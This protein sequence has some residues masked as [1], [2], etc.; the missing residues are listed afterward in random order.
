[1][2]FCTKCGAQNQDE[3]SVCNQCGTPLFPT[4]MSSTADKKKIVIVASAVFSV[5]VI[6][7]FLIFTH[8]ICINHVFLPAT[9]ISPQ[10]CQYCK[11]TQGEPSEHKWE[12]ATCIAPKYCSVCLQSVGEPSGHTWVDATCVDPKTCS[13]CALTDGI[14]KGHTWQAATCSIPETCVDCGLTQG[15]PLGHSVD[16]WNL[17]SASTCTTLGIEGGTCSICNESVEQ[18]LPLADHILGDWEVVAEPSAT[19]DGKHIKKCTHCGEQLESE[20]F[21]LSA[22]ELQKYYK[23]KSEKISYEKL[24]RTPSKYEGK[25]IRFR[26][27]VVQVCSEA[28]SSLYYSSYR[29]ATSSY[30]GNVIYIYVDNYGSESRILED[31]TIDFYGVFDGLYTYETVLGAT[32]TI[33]CMTV[34]YVAL[35]D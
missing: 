24:A 21:S 33:P 32:V 7:L 17:I 5:I 29:V 19:N 25:F 27:R 3:S 28:T 13:T 34:E 9:C 11:K 4:S 12:D 10:I 18:D 20:N 14:S 26:G 6:L 22:E 30:G 2:K 15:D 23:N 31:D 35:V 8:V 16:E 1:M